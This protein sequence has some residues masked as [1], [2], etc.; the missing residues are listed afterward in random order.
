MVVGVGLV[1]EAAPG[2]IHRDHTWFGAVGDQ[3]REAF[4]FATG[5]AQFGNRRPEE[6]GRQAV[7]L[8][9]RHGLAKA[10]GGAVVAGR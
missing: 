4:T 5:M 6:V 3:V 2:R 1:D 8:G 10:Q 7:A 9:R